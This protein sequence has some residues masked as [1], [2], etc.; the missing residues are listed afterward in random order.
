M[1]RPCRPIGRVLGADSPASAW[2]NLAYALQ[3]RGQV[4]GGRA[5]LPEAAQ[6]DPKNAQLW[7]DAGMLASQAGPSGRTLAA[8]ALTKA[9]ALGTDRA[10]EAQFTRGEVHAAQGK[11]AEAAADFEAAAKLRPDQF[12]PWYNLGAVEARAGQP[13]EAEAAYRRALALKPATEL[14]RPRRALGLLLA[15]TADKAGRAGP[16]SRTRPTADVGTQAI[17]LNPADNATRLALA[18]SQMR[19]KKY[20]AAAAQYEAL[21]RREPRNAS[22]QVASGLAYRGA[23]ATCPPRWRPSGRH[24]RWTRTTPRRRTTW[25]WFTRNR[26]IGAQALAAYRKA[27]ALDPS[28][29]EPKKNLAR[30]A[31]R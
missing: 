6:R 21:A 9:L 17:Q 31:G 5:G 25:A 1:R 27:A 23:W 18:N 16:I 22:V 19:Q 30:L 28:L 13:A 7:Q 26:A 24:S 20:D 3:K 2:Q 15:A 11:L 8:A 29:P 4:R 10:Y 14:P 12:A